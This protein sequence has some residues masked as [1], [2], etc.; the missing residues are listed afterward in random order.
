MDIGAPQREALLTPV[1]IGKRPRF[2]RLRLAVLAVALLLGIGLTTR[3]LHWQL[4]HVVLDDARVASDMVLLA[5]RVPGWVEALPVTAGDRLAAGALLV[6]IDPREQALAV[7]ELDAQIEG[8]AARRSELEARLTMIDRVSGSQHDAARATLDAARAALLAAQ[9]DRV[10]AISELG[11]AEGLIAAGAGTRQRLEQLHALSSQAEQ[12]VTS[13]AA[14]IR[15]AEAMIAVAQA[16]REEMQVL[17]R[18]I[19]S[20]GPQARELAARRGRAALDLADRSIR[21]PFDGVVDR[22]FLDPGEYVL[23]G[24]RIILVHDPA[25]VRVEANVRETD[26]RYFRPGT[27]VRVSV[28]A[29]PGRVFEGVVDRVVEAATSEFALLPSANPSGNFTRITQRMP[30]RVQLTPRPEPGIL[31]P[32]M[33]VR[34]EAEAR[35]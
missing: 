23:A 2:R 24:Q 9:S 28:D 32:G 7:A 10:F 27:S 20:L 16:S 19:D 22:I 29:W 5:S 13:R 8:I 14:E 3:W 25:Q 21:M 17:A 35:D 4:T 26:L 31:R 30:L 15:N 1:P 18:Q 34:V 12:R 33:L 11:R 6:Q